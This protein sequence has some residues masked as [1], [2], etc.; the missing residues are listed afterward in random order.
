MHDPTPLQV[1]AVRR[2]PSRQIV[3]PHVVAAFGKRQRFGSVPS[4]VPSQE[5]VPPQGGRTPRGLPEIVLHVPR[6]EGSSQTSHGR[7]HGVSQHTPSTHRP[8]PHCDVAPHGAPGPWRGTQTPAE[9]YWSPLQFASV[10]QLP[11]HSVAPQ[12][13]GVHGCARS[14]VHAPARLQVCARI[15]SPAVQLAA[16]QVTLTPG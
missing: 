8:L 4:H 10:A 2:R 6:L 13:N 5:P 15:A 9:Q 16:P 3:A 1:G 12:A 14:G 11:A 7:L